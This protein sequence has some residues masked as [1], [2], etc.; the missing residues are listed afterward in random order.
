VR[1]ELFKSPYAL[2]LGR[3]TYDIFECRPPR[4]TSGKTHKATSRGAFAI[5]TSEIYSFR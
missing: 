3:R 1:G 5:P 2:L 4:L